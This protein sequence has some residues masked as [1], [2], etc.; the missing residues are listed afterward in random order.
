MRGLDPFSNTSASRQ[1]MVDA[2]TDR[3]DE[4]RF[5]AHRHPLRHRSR[6]F[7]EGIQGWTNR[8]TSAWQPTTNVLGQN[9]SSEPYQGGREAAM[10]YYGSHALP[11]RLTQ[12]RGSTNHRQYLQIGH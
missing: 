2:E 3:R 10:P 7:Y 8:R 5:A 12:A 6:L 1:G 4:A 11:D 9:L